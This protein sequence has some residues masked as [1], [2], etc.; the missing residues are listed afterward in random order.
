MATS[1]TWAVTIH[2]NLRNLFSRVVFTEKRSIENRAL[3]KTFG[4]SLRSRGLGRA[5]RQQGCNNLS[6]ISIFYR[7]ETTLNLVRKSRTCEIVG[8]KFPLAVFRTRERHVI[9]GHFVH[10]LSV[11]E[12]LVEVG[13]VN[14]ALFTGRGKLRLFGFRIQCRFHNTRRNTDALINC[15]EGALVRLAT[16]VGCASAIRP[17][18]EQRMQISIGIIN[19]SSKVVLAVSFDVRLLG[20]PTISGIAREF[21]RFSLVRY[22]IHGVMIVR[23]LFKQFEQALKRN[24][25][26]GTFFHQS[27]FTAHADRFFP[28]GIIISMNSHT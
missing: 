3:S 19:H 22:K 20:I 15:R 26:N 28:L 5:V 4:T 12:Q 6:V 11:A 17:A 16:V 14:K 7:I 24:G 2:V 10:T 21:I 18:R 9:A 1:P 23:I 8:V 13:I 27:F 25:F